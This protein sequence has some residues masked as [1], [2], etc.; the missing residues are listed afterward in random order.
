M[1]KDLLTIEELNERDLSEII[2]LASEMK[3]KRKSWDKK[4]LAGKSVGMI[5][6]KSSTRTRVSFEVAIHELGGN[7]IFMDMS[8]LQLKRGETFADTAKVMSRYLHAVVIRTSKHEY[9]VEFAKAAN[10]PVINA[11]TDSFHPCQV[12]A[13]LFTIYEYSERLEG[14]KVAYLG[15][16]SNN[17]A[18]SLILGAKLSGLNLVLSSPEEFAPDFDLIRNP[19]MGKGNIRWVKDPFEAVKDADYIYTDVWVS[20]G[21][22]REA[23]KRIKL[24]E[25]FRINRAIV[26]HASPAVR[27]M[28]CLPA[29]RGEEITDDIIDDNR[30]SI[31]LDQAENR[32]HVQKA[33]L[34]LMFAPNVI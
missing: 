9:I 19:D 15:D 1:Q 13:D 27:V 31:V 7:S 14:V 28:H 34:S 6:S 10:I 12:V 16:C 8:D 20:M 3:L 5:F 23:K 30:I 33:I 11:L 2:R 26:E 17:I 4:P 18:N 21:F 25:P 32:L 24:L 29:H 22:E